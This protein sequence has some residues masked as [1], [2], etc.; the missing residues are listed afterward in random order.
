M[1]LN[2]GAEIGRYPGCTKYFALSGEDAGHGRSAQTGR[3]VRL[4][5]AQ[6][7][8]E[9]ATEDLSVDFFG[10]YFVGHICAAF[11]DRASE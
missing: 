10:R 3:I 4:R 1:R 8:I 6:G 2:L 7:F 11:D 5:T 9:A